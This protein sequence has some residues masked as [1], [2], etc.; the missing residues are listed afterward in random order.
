MKTYPELSPRDLRRMHTRVIQ[1]LATAMD[2][3]VDEARLHMIMKSKGY[4]ILIRN[5]EG[6]KELIFVKK[7]IATDKDYE[8]TKV[9]FRVFSQK[10]NVFWNSFR[11][12]EGTLFTI[13]RFK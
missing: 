6:P 12:C 9:P 5:E 4:A 13:N 2:L 10:H 1:G 7:E 11:N 8:E 3:T